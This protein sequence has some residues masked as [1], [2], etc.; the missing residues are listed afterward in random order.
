MVGPWP[1]GTVESLR[2]RAVRA[3][4]GNETGAMGMFASRSL[5]GNMDAVVREKNW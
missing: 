4:E 2:F 5:V 3:D 1:V